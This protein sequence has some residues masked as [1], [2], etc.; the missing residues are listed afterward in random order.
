MGWARVSRG[1][2][3]GVVRKLM[4]AARIGADCG[5]TLRVGEYQPKKQRHGGHCAAPTNQSASRR[6]K[7]SFAAS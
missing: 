3:H 1:L 4:N 2:S 5:A 7:T 6:A